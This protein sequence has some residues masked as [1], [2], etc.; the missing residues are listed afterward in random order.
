MGFRVAGFEGDLIWAFLG[1]RRLRGVR[2]YFG[3]GGGGGWRGEF[4]KARDTDSRFRCS[5]L[6]RSPSSA[7]QIQAEGMGI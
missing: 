5:F 4:V 3:G 2:R 6:Q 1:F 7:L